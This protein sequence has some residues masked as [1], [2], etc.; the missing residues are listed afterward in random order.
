[1]A[2]DKYSSEWDEVPF[3]SSLP[4]HIMQREMFKPF[5]EKRFEQLKAMSPIHKLTYKYDETQD[6]KGTILEH[7]IQSVDF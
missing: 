6:I 5:S 1:M 3:I 2:A 7:I 4:P